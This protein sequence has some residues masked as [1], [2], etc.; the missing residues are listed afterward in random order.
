VV[1]GISDDIGADYELGVT[2]KYWKASLYYF[3]KFKISFIW[4]QKKNVAHLLA[5]TS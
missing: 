1:D 4:R 3:T 5:S 2:L